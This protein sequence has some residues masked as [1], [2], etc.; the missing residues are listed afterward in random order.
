[1]SAKG[2]NFLNYIMALDQGTSSS[3]AIIYDAAGEVVTVAQTDID[4]FFPADG[5]VEQDPEQLWQSIL[6]VGRQAIAQSGLAADAIKAIGITNQRETTLLWERATGNCVHNALVWQDR[7]TAPQCQQMASDTLADGKPVAQSISDITG[8][9]ID[10]YFSSTKLGWLLDNVAGA[11]AAA[12]DGQLCFGTVDSFLLWKL[13]KGQRHVTDAT[14]ASRTQ[15]FDINAQVWSEELLA[16][17][18]IPQVILPEVMD[19]AAHFAVADAEWFGAPIPIT[20]VAGDQQAALIGQACFS[21]G[22]SKSTYGTGCF[23]MTNT[24]AE[25]SHSKQRLLTTVAYR[26]A[27]QTCY[28]LEGSIFVAGVAIKWLRDQL[29]LIDDAAETQAAF[30]RCQG[31]SNGVVVVPAFTGLGAP[32]WQPDVR[33]LITGL[34]LDSSRDHV[35]TATLQSVVLQTAELLRAMAGDGAAVKT[36]RVDGGMVVNDAL[37]QFLADILDVQVQRPQDVETTAKGAAV[38]AA[39]GS[40][41]LADL[42]DAASAWQ[43]DQTYTAQMPAETRQQLL[44]N[45]ARAVTQ[46]L[47]G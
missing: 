13:S 3:R 36:L 4:L 34:T 19:S 22:M 41:Q 20:G 40:G 6:T 33:G 26:I 7:R 43:L 21:A 11:R 28:A 2:D 12:Q 23:A 10:P 32:H 8:L 24:G 1:M 9:I 38:L 45:Y 29:G 31:D 42:Q 46:A 14:N 5:W 44:D 37:C 17:F 25:R 47:A 27:G 39:L 15:L 30:E 35:I 18:D 16:Y